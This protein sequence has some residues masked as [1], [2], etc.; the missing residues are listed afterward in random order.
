MQFSLCVG[1]TFRDGMRTLELVRELE[2]GQY[3]IEDVLTRLPKVISRANLVNA[4]FNGKYRVVFGSE[5]AADTGK[6]W[7][8]VTDLASLSPKEQSQLEFRLRF[9]KALQRKKIGRGQRHRVSALIA[10]MSVDSEKKPSASSVM[11]WVRNYENSGLNPLSLIDRHRLRTT[12]KRICPHAEDL[13]WRVLKR[14]YMTPARHSLQHVHDVLTRAL[15]REVAAGKLPEAESAISYATVKRRIDDI[16]LYQRIAARE[17]HARARLVC[18]TS[19]PDGHAEYPMERI[20]IDHTPLNWVVLCD[21]TGLPLG[22]PLLTFAL[23]QYSS[24]PLGF[25]I[26]FHGPGLTSVSGVLRN[27][28]LPKDHL[29]NGLGLTHTWDSY[30]LGD[31]WVLDNG[32]EFHSFGFNKIAQVLGV[33]VTYCK[34]RTPWMKPQV[35]RFFGTLNYLTLVRGRVSKTVANIVRIDPYKDA[36]INFSDLVKGLLK[37]F[38]DVYAQNPNWRK[39]GTPSELYSEGIARCPPAVFP[40]NLDVKVQ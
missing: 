18:R 10:E 37:F 17:G 27:A 26:S 14:E 12:P 35:E 5:A 36:A 25:Y 40:G 24:Y 1:L 32:L 6:Q 29:L 8:V 34:V 38:V 15:S 21:R 9:V 3:Q 31:E 39:M 30:G 28:I 4:I 2:G 19:M 11:A 7:P 16:D 33:D 13:L 22:R 20:Q 23:D